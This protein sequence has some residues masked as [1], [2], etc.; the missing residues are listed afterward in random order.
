MNNTEFTL[1]LK[2]IMEF[3]NTTAAS[4]A[5][6]IAVPRSSISHIL[7]GRNK[8]SLDFVLKI[9]STYLDVDLYWLL[10]GR[11][12]FPREDS[13]NNSSESSVLKK[14]RRIPTASNT[15]PTPLSP[16][17]FESEEENNIESKI[18]TSKNDETNK[19]VKNIASRDA[20]KELER[21]VMFYTDGTFEEF[22]K[23]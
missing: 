5:E 16:S 17:L 22:T 12:T 19:Q 15:T 6:S 1:R 7:S 20:N 3:Y 21:I 8:P 18:L 14:S 4:F 11:G 2:K 23:K 10:E 13:E 9:T